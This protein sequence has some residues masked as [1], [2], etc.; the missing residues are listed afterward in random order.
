M[1]SGRSSGSP[2][3]RRRKPKSRQ[4]T[5]RAPD[6]PTPGDAVDAKP[7]PDSKAQAAPR[8]AS[9]PP[10]PTGRGGAFAFPRVPE[11][12]G[13]GSRLFR[14][15]QLGFGREGTDRGLR[16]RRNRLGRGGL[17]NGLASNIL[18]KLDHFRIGLLQVKV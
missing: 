12:S 6:F 16:A 2:A 11:S 14:K 5:R 17:G 8:S 15:L 3:G 7:K 9:P 13:R 4:G 10:V 18:R 1:P